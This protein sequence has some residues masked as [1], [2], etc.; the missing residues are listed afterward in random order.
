MAPRRIPS[1]NWLRVFETAA[2]FESFARAAEALNMSAP[3]VSQQVRALEAHLQRPLFERSAR[4]VRLNAAG[5]A[6]LPAVSRALRDV[7]VAA[8]AVSGAPAAARVTV[9]A[10]MLFLTGWLAPRLPAF[11]ADHGEAQV[12]LVTADVSDAEP[13]AVLAS[14][15]A[16]DVRIV[17]GAPRAAATG[18]AIHGQALF[19]E[20]LRP[21]AAPEIAGRIRGVSDLAKERLI[22]ISTH[23]ANWHHVMAEAG[24]AIEEG[25]FAYADNSVSALSLAASG[26]GVALAREPA[27]DGLVS[28]FGLAPCL[29][30]PAT[31]GFEQYF[32]EIPE[33]GAA[34]AAVLHFTT[35]LL[36]E[37]RRSASRLTAP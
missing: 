24:V 25:R 33:R 32:A 9:A 31:P 26:V 19:R 11:L 34:R 4:S 35:W 8:G 3:A 1:L 15:E 36:A 18:S 20:S 28:R 7:E 29:D 22:E 23:R 30:G 13:G 2:R 14:A 5:L 12:S 17:F 21:V 10:P 16:A 37:A 27:T 6:F